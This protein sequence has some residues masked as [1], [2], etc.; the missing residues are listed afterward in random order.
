[1]NS[2]NVIDLFTGKS[3]Q[4]IFNQAQDTKQNDELVA[5]Y[6]IYL[7]CLAKPHAKQLKQ[8][9]AQATALAAQIVQLKSEYYQVCSDKDELL[10]Y[11]LDYL[12]TGTSYKIPED[13][14]YIDEDAHV[15]VVSQNSTTDTDR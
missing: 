8:M 15:W 13:N 3:Y 12:E 4:K 9:Q 1:M 7:G 10:E 2:S 14:I 6:G 11:C 5:E